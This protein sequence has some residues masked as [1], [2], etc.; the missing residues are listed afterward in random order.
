LA[1]SK[2]HVTRT[3]HCCP[4]DQL[5]WEQFEQLTL[6][7]AMK[8]GFR[9]AEHYGA[10]G[11]D[12]A[13]DIVDRKKGAYFQCKNQKSFPP[14]AVRQEIDKIKTHKGVKLVVFVIAGKVSPKSRDL[15]FELL[16]NIPCEFWCESKLDAMVKDSFTILRDYF[17][18]PESRKS[19]K[20]NG[21][22]V[23]RP[24]VG[25]I[26]VDQNGKINATDDE[27]AEYL[28]EIIAKFENSKKIG[29][30]RIQLE[31]LQDINLKLKHKQYSSPDHKIALMR[32]KRGLMDIS[33]RIER[34]LTLLGLSWR[35]SGSLSDK[36]VIARTVVRQILQ[37]GGF[38]EEPRQLPFNQR[39]ATIDIFARERSYPRQLQLETSR[40][41]C[42]EIEKRIG[43]SVY[44]T[45]MNGQSC[46]LL[47][48]EFLW[49]RAYPTMIVATVWFK[50][51]PSDDRLAA[52]KC[53]RDNWLFGLA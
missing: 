20:P 11:N 50:A 4:F 18:Y 8:N 19:T 15:A 51:Y 6:K 12:K 7:L 24:L 36:A 29:R 9:N 35:F 47:P 10:T 52:E 26:S 21:T 33:K 28:S 1:K 22:R 40:R 27:L 53:D 23:N 13:R 32:S 38:V 41:E 43:F 30:I 46:S 14:K 34:A 17:D 39:G 42:E 44:G 16:G 37:L 31:K 49:F 5:S 2:P 48:P 3:T 25:K 45:V